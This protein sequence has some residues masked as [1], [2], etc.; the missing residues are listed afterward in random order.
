MQACIELVHDTTLLFVDP[1]LVIPY[2]K[3]SEAIPNC[4]YFVP[5][6]LMM[7]CVV[8]LGSVMKSRWSIIGLE[9]EMLVPEIKI[10]SMV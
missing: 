4:T 6:S 5:I 9:L 7:L 1:Q 3:F 8:P 2:P 10:S